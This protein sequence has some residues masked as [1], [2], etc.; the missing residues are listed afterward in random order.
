MVIDTAHG[1][2]T[3]VAKAVERGQAGTVALGAGRGRQ[4]RHGEG[5]AG[6][7]RCRRGRGEGRHRPG[8]DLHHA[9]RGGRRRAADDG[10]PRLRRRGRATVPVIADGGI[11][12]SGDFAKAIAAGAHCAMIG[13][14]LAGT[15]E[16]P[17]EVILYQGRSYKSYRGMGS[18]GAMARGSADRYF[19]KEASA[20]KLVPEGIE[21]Q[22]PYKGPVA[23]VGGLRAAM[24]TSWSAG[25]ARRWATPATPRSRETPLMREAAANGKFVRITGAGLRESHVHDVQITVG[26]A[27]T[28]IDPIDSFDLGLLRRVEALIDAVGG[29]RRIECH[30][31]F[32]EGGT[33]TG[34]ADDPRAVHAFEPARADVCHDQGTCP[35]S[36][37]AL[38]PPS[39]RDSC[40]D[41]DARRPRRTPRRT[42]CVPE[43]RSFAGSRRDA[44]RHR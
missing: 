40:R 35:G 15:D 41:A 2:S 27:R 11:K 31:H 10:D 29:Q 7:D 21:G 17:G 6:A 24:S 16:A 18:V 23:L 43:R 9:D 13:S 39:R 30:R 1:H 3:S 28:K 5:D 26:R 8:L 20:R 33:I 44:R 38:S 36:G 14:M 22:V 42:G 25:C 4:R 37:G 32:D 12:Y 34:A 19:Q